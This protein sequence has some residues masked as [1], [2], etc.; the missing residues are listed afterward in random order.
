MHTL[1]ILATVCGLALPCLGSVKAATQTSPATGFNNVRSFGAQGDGVTDDR[2]AIQ[3]AIDDAVANRKAGI[4]IPAGTYRVSRATG[5]ADRWSLDLDGVTDFTVLGQ[6]PSSVVKLVDTTATTGNWH[7]FIL[8]NGC[9]RVL[10]RDLVIDGNRLGLTN[11]SEQS[12]GIEVED[13][14]YDLSIDGCTLRDCFGDGVRLL[15]ADD[16]AGGL[17]VKRLRIANTLFQTNKRSGLA[18]QRALEQILVSNCV[19]DRTVS[20]QEIDFEPSGNDA[21]CEFIIDGCIIY[22]T[23][24]TAPVSLSGIS[25]PDPLTRVKFTNNLVIG[26]DVFCTDIDQLTFQNNT[27][28]VP[29]LGAGQRIPLQVQR[30]GDSLVIT[31]NLLVND[32]SAT[33]VALALT[34]VNGRQVTRALV[35]N[36]LCITRSGTGIECL[37]SD[38]ISIENNM[39]VAT[40]ACSHGIFLRS[41]SSDMDGISI[42][43]NDITAEGTGSWT[44]GIRIAALDHDIGHLSVVENSIRAAAQGIRFE[45]PHFQQTPVCALNRI[46]SSVP[47][48]FVGLTN[49]PEHCL[50]S[51]GATSVG[52]TA[53]A[54]GG[55]RTLLGLGDPTSLVRGNVGDLFQRLDGG[56]GSTFYVK[57]SG[58][59]TTTGWTAK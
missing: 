7:V 41:Q 55:G 51:G 18:V 1:S 57:E 42:R 6:G 25:G 52:G 24:A 31:G 58:N 43:G 19:F 35:A 32:A 3:A 8:R 36:N 39:I 34:E 2:A 27:V 17:N 26:G 28:Y 11:P 29:E 13:G 49:F 46:D 12:H 56:A 44:Y 48:P 22:H 14:T 47:I 10:F 37:S 16:A 53:S 23:N 45:Y 50:V 20:D 9:Q 33:K 30:G 5:A 4:L 59:G 38:D 40:G 21:P 15:G 54:S